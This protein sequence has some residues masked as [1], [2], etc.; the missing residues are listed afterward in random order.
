[1]KTVL[2][3]VGKSFWPCFVFLTVIT[4]ESINIEIRIRTVSLSIFEASFLE[5]SWKMESR[6]GRFLESR[7]LTI[8]SRIL[9][10]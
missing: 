8:A 2:S 5:I 1:M 10:L 6:S 4:F 3:S 9:G 7:I